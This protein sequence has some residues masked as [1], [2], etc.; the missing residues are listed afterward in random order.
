MLDR[1]LYVTNYLL[2]RDIA[3]RSLTV[4][5]DDTFIVSYPRSGNTWTRFLAGNLL[6]PNESI[7]FENIERLIPEIYLD[8]KKFLN[9]LPRP[10]ILKS[11][12]Y[13]DLRYKRVVYIVRD[14]RDV[15][16][17]GYH[18]WLKQGKIN[19]SV[20]I[21][22]FALSLLRREFWDDL[23]T[24]RENVGGW[25]AARLG[26][27][28]FLLLK[29]EDMLWQPEVE[30][31][32]LA[33]FLSL[34]RDAGQIARAVER[35]KF[36]EMQ[37]LEKI[38]SDKWFLTKNTRK[39]ISFIRKAVAGGW[40]QVLSPESLQAIEREWGDLMQFLNYD[41]VTR[42]VSREQTFWSSSERKEMVNQRAAAAG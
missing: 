30:I 18:F 17:S 33:E 32:K 2:G 23:G 21:N 12:E 11:H 40:K 29:Y 7:S 38:Q 36:N 6:R 25:L 26:T 14:P 5:P 24:W 42:Q 4:F 37:R 31:A 22:D 16:V 9:S 15:I 3:G 41:L 10:R 13:L 8:S 28:G 20:T 27:E 35:S 19:E 39:D 34:K 1:V